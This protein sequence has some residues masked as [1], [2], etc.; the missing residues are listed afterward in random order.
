MALENVGVY[1]RLMYKRYKNALKNECPFL[2]PG[3]EAQ[4]A[5]KMVALLE[6]V[7]LNKSDQKSVLI[8][9]RQKKAPNGV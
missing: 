9:Y 7:Y 1:Q 2:V 3:H 4:M 6:P 8:E 5:L